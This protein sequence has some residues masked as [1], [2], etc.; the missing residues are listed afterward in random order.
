[1]WVAALLLALVAVGV[2]AGALVAR[3]RSR[4]DEAGRS[5]ERSE[6]AAV[7]ATARVELMRQAVDALPQGVIITDE[8]GQLLIR[9][10]AAASF[11]GAPHADALVDDALAEPMAAALEGRREQ[12]TVTLYGP[13]RRH[14]EVLALPYPIGQGRSGALVEIDDVTEKVRLEAV[15]T[16]FV[17]NISH[18][19]KTPV[20]ALALLAETLADEHDPDLVER[21]AGKLVA[22][23]HRVSRIIDDLLELSRIEGAEHPVREPVPVGLVVAEAV[24]RVRPVA[25]ERTIHI[26]VREPS[27][28]LEVMGDR[29][30]LVSAVVNLLDNACK[31]SESGAGV[32]VGCYSDGSWVDL[33]V[34][35]HGLG[36]PARDLDR[37]FERFYRVDRA[38]S[39]ETGGTGLGLAIVRHVMNNHG[40]SVSVTS[41]E[42]AGSTFTLRLPA[43]RPGPVAVSLPEAG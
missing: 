18:E 11:L 40:G 8:R 4:A 33:V 34:V 42:G 23:A 32:E 26:T 10:A 22:E 16:D 7:D 29:R 14:I 37:V 28:R 17:A 9:N 20:G 31:Y 2:A 19:L 30:Q 1:M 3:A 21:L 25:D 12:R 24:D 36:I 27:H 41:E 13:P 43:G 15:R 35:D 5:A 38:R 39:R 6:R